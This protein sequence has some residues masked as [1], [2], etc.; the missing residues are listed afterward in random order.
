MGLFRSKPSAE[1]IAA[2]AT[3]T[4]FGRKLAEKGVYEEVI[5]SM[6]A[7]ERR[8]VEDA[9]DRHAARMRAEGQPGW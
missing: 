8:Q 5:G 7:A 6:P 4:L 2:D 1:D 3:T 9:M